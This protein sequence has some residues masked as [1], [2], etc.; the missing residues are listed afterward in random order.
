MTWDT[1]TEMCRQVMPGVHLAAITSEQENNAVVGYLQ[2][3]FSGK[4]TET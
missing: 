1:A 2:S 4:H 3:H